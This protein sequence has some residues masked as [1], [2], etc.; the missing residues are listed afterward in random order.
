VSGYNAP[1]LLTWKIT[2]GQTTGVP[3]CDTAA[4]IPFSH[5]Y[6]FYQF[7]PDMLKI[8]VIVFAFFCLLC[9]ASEAREKTNTIVLEPHTHDALTIQI[10][11]NAKVIT[12][13]DSM[14]LVAPNKMIAGKYEMNGNVK[15]EISTDHYSLSLTA[16]HALINSQ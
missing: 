10:P 13:S 12:S 1:A 9:S 2:P 6:T 5:S 11:K 7:R 14:A 8:N 15:I 4:V 16:E 3:A